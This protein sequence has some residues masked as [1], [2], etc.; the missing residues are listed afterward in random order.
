MAFFIISL[1]INFCIL[2]KLFTI[3][4]TNSQKYLKPFHSDQTYKIYML[5]YFILLLY[6]LILFTCTIHFT[7]RLMHHYFEFRMFILKE[8][9]LIEFQES[10]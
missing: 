7:E 8:L 4:I 10:I 9:I 2:S 3:F 6:N 5:Y 1:F